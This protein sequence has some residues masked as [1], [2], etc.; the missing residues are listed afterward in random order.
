MSFMIGDTPTDVPADPKHNVVVV[1]IEQLKPGPSMSDF[2]AEPQAGST[3]RL[4]VR[5]TVDSAPFRIL[6]LLLILVNTVVLSLEY[7]GMPG[8]W[9]RLSSAR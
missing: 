6:I 5:R 7:H 9:W 2:H 4:V 1:D 3:P 8:G